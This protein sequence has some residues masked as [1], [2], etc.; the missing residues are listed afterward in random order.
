MARIRSIKPES[1]LSE[2]LAEL[3][4]RACL[5]FAYLPCFCDDEGRMRYSPRLIK[6][7]LFPLRDGIT[8]KD[9]GALVEELE[10]HGLVIVY[11]ADGETLLQ[12]TNF[13]EHQHPQKPKPSEFPAPVP[14]QYR[15]G[16]VTVPEREEKKGN[17]EKRGLYQGKARNTVS[18]QEE[19]S[20]DTASRVI[21][22]GEG[23]VIGEVKEKEKEKEKAAPGA[24]EDRCTLETIRR[25][26]T[27][28]NHKTGKNFKHSTAST[29]RA[30]RA[31][32]KEGFRLPDFFRVIDVKFAQWGR[33]S[34]M[35]GYLRPETLFGSKFDGYLNERMPGDADGGERYAAYN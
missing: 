35:A 5:L 15:S 4:D 12:V 21:V 22:K 32:W 29:Q 16:T 28:L 17:S 31:R 33:D 20:S 23:V 34:R 3:S 1:C 10:S 8:T 13:L 6:A 2:T 25:I 9:C 14:V 19:Y 30:I 11:E 7:Q 24:D 27:Y 18:V 26:V